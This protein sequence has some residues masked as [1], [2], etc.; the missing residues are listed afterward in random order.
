MEKFNS[1]PVAER[2]YSSFVVVCNKVREEHLPKQLPRVSPTVD[3]LSMSRARKDTL[4]TTSS[5]VQHQ[6][7]QRSTFDRL[8]DEKI[9]QT[10]A[11]FENG[12]KKPKKA[13]KLTKELPERK[14]NV[15]LIRGEDKMSTSRLSAKC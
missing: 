11:K 13:R 9:N 12:T 10:V 1:L 3:S 4:K 8:E 15:V 5:S 6:I 2:Q 7:K 14:K